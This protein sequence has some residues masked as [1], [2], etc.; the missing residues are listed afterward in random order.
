MIRRPSVDYHIKQLDISPPSASDNSSILIIVDTLS[1]DD[2]QLFP[3]VIFHISLR[4]L[5]LP[6]IRD[7]IQGQLI[8]RSWLGPEISTAATQLGFSSTELLRDPLV[9]HRWLSDY[10]APH[11]SD[12]ASELGFGRNGFS[13]S[14]VVKIVTQ[15]TSK[16]E[17]LSR[18]VQQG[19]MMNREELKSSQ[20]Q[21]EP[22]SICLNNLV[23]DD[24]SSSKHGVPT[25]LTC[26]H[27]FHDGCL[28][29]WFQRKDTCPLC[30]TLLYDP[31][32]VLNN[33]ELMLSEKNGE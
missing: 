16:Y 7:L 15:S 30:R 19:K 22:C 8:R 11:I 21:T 27:V 2:I 17:V 29:E 14:I 9:I 28:L 26:S 12:L 18:M 33:G 5:G 32:M 31:S 23:F 6:H 4:S 25:R 10:L 1:D 24:G 3:S 20:T 13:V